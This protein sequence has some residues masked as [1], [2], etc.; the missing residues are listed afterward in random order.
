M[1]PFLLAAIVAL[2][3]Y[4]NAAFEQLLDARTNGTRY[5]PPQRLMTSRYIMLKRRIAELEEWQATRQYR[6][7]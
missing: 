1:T 7:T 4:A 5:L 6:I 3:F 2:G